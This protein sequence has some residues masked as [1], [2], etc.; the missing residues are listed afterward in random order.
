MTVSHS[1]MEIKKIIHQAILQNKL[2]HRD[3]DRIMEIAY[4]DGYLDDQERHAIAY[5]RDLI[6]EK[7]VCITDD[8]D[9]PT[10]CD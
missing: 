9:S 7:T 3:Y 8:L 6:D 2:T 5:L 1:A 4:A 10:R